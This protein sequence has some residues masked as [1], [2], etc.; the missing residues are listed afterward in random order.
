MER[1]ALIIFILLLSSLALLVLL[2]YGQQAQAPALSPTAGPAAA[3]SVKPYSALINLTGN[4]TQN[5]TVT[6]APLPTEIGHTR[7][8]ASL[9][10]PTPLPDQM[11]PTAMAP[12]EAMTPWLPVE[13]WD[14]VEAWG[15]SQK[16]APM[17]E[18]TPMLPSI[19]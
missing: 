16:M 6:P 4:T 19:S 13:A 17:A 7:S 5:V 14:P 15:P 8:E 9:S 18:M 3:V 1:K 12:W 11:T 2:Q 10:T